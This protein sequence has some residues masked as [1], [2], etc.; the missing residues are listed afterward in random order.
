MDSIYVGVTLI[1]QMNKAMVCSPTLR[2]LVT[3][4]L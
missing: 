2:L 1:S 4:N 3:L